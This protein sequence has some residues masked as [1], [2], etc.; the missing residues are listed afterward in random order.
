MAASVL[1]F[2]N[3]EKLQNPSI[4]ISTGGTAVRNHPISSSNFLGLLYGFGAEGVRDSG[5]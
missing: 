3:T 2:S 1:V 5:L 4:A